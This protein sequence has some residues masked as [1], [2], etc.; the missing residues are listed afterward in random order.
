MDQLC[1]PSRIAVTEASDLTT[2]GTKAPLSGSAAAYTCLRIRLIDGL[3][4]H[5]EVLKRQSINLSSGVCRH[6]V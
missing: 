6:L 3:L 4:N 2:N 5:Q 1:G